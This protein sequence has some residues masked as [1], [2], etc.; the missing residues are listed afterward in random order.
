MRSF[1]VDVEDAA[2]NRV[3]S[4]PITTA[5][6]WEHTPRLDAAGSFSFAMPASDPK[7]ALLQHKRIA[8]CRAVIG[9]VVADLGAGIIDEINV[10]AGDPTMLTVSGPDILAELATRTVGRLAVCEQQWVSLDD[11]TRSMVAWFRNAVVDGATVPDPWIFIPEAHDGD[12]GTYV[13]IYLRSAP[14]GYPETRTYL[15]VGHDARFDRAE[16]TFLP[17]GRVNEQTSTMTPQYYN[18]SGWAP[19]PI[20]ADGTSVGGCTWAQNGTITW[21]RPADWTRYTAA[22]GAG[23]WFW[24]RFVGSSN[25]GSVTGPGDA[26]Y[27]DLAEVRAYA[28]VPTT[29]GIN[30]IMYHAPTTWVRSGYPATVA[31]KYIEF[32]GESVLSALIMLCEQG[33]QSG[34]APVREHFRLGTGREIDWLGTSTPASGIRATQAGDAVA[35]EGKSELCLIE[36]L[37]ER[38]DSTEAVTRIYPW[39]QDGINLALTTRSAPAGY[40]LSKAGNYLQHNAG[41]SA[42]GLI[43]A[44]VRFTDVSMQQSDSYTEHPVMAANALFDRALEYLRTHGEAQRFYDLSVAQFP[45]L[46]RPGETIHTV[47]HE[48]VDGYHSVDIDTVVADTP[49]HILAP[50]VRISEEGVGT[51]ALEVATIDRPAQSD[52][53]VLVSTIQDVRRMKSQSGGGV[54]TIF[55]TGGGVM[56]DG[57]SHTKLADVLPNQHHDPVTLTAAAGNLLSLSGQQVDMP[58]VSAA[59]VLASPIEDA[60]APQFLAD[61]GLSSLILTTK[62]TTP[63]I[64]APGTLSLSPTTRT[65]TN[66]T[67]QSNPHV[68]RFTGW[69]MTQHGELDVRYIYSDEMRVK[70][71]IAEMET[72]LAGAQII[73]KSVA[74]VARDFTLPTA[75]G[76]A[77]L[78]VEDLAGAANVAVFQAGDIVRLRQFSRAAGELVVA[79][80][81]GVVTSYADGSGTDEGLQRWVFTRSAAPNAGTATGII[82]AKALALDYGVSGN[83]TYE[84]SAVDGVWGQNAPYA[85]V[86]KWTNH[87]AT[88]RGVRARLGNLRGVFGVADEIGLFAGDGT[89]LSSKYLRVSSQGITMHN[90]PFRIYDGATAAIRAEPIANPY[91]SVGGPAPEAYLGA[92]GI[93]FGKHDGA[94]K[95]HI[96]S[97]SGGNLAAGFSWNGAQLTVRGKVYV[98]PG[99]LQTLDEWVHP[100]DATMI[101]GGKIYTGSITAEKLSLKGYNLLQNPGFELPNIPHWGL[102]GSSQG[103]PTLNA[104]SYSGNYMLEGRSDGVGHTWAQQNV[105]GIEVGANYLASCMFRFSGNGGTFY[106]V[107]QWRKADGTQISSN[108]TPLSGTTTWQRISAIV[109]APAETVFATYNLRSHTDVPSGRWTHMDDCV[110][111]RADTDLVVGDPAAARVHI[112][113]QGIRGFNASGVT[114]MRWD[115]TGT[116]AGELITGN[117]PAGVKLNRDGIHLLD[118]SIW[119]GW[120]GGSCGTSIYVSEAGLY[121]ISLTGERL[122]VNNKWCVAPHAL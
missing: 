103:L 119:T 20:T 52:S 68:D 59:R 22:F 61:A 110:F 66:R 70:S 34:S 26:G 13:S 15:Y 105:Y 17:G 104:A 109:K 89:S 36:S 87:P 81:W 21:N 116:H 1:W 91:F 27:I 77:H 71:F 44:W 24:V 5:T 88:G 2:G 113:P 55:V 9:G 50:T 33:G 73:S 120:A 95:A 30:Q 100:T 86:V 65:E 115:T 40:T 48:Y 94:Y 114:Q 32:D 106:L 42:L 25:V 18:G 111:A 118:T 19:L 6:N 83:G 112:S 38:H 29:D 39:S 79:D 101:D 117:Y 96:G 92:S 7:A 63:L 56:P 58:D 23:D 72:A 53:G 54:G 10:D 85:Q 121:Y 4:G 67:I 3:G 46:L 62:L 69:R 78:W 93:W 76:W 108:W 11:S 98:T 45:K 49:L 82:E 102:G 43:E 37:Q 64:E 8:R 47:Y 84:V 41:V 122:K 14:A 31:E 90:L 99:G 35:A 16:F 28:D 97:V 60:G 51:I 75:G 107:V 74:V 57:Y 12:A 80:A